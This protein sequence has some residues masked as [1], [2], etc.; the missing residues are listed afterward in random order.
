MVDGSLVW[1]K[2]M[3]T[4][5][6]YM[7]LWIANKE[8]QGPRRNFDARFSL[9]YGKKS[10]SWYSLDQWFSTWKWRA[11]QRL[12][13]ICGR[14]ARRYFKYIAVF[15]LLY[16]SLDVGRWVIVGCYNG[17]RYKKGWKPLA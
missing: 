5:I 2:G 12:W 17:S 15:H 13:T 1:S 10:F 3:H 4:V 7:N 6:H 9:S 16:P 8:G 11:P 14:V